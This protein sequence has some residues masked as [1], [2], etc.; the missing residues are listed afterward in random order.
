MFS[1][2]LNDCIL[3]AFSHETRGIMNYLAGQQGRLRSLKQPS[4]DDTHLCYPESKLFFQSRKKFSPSPEESCQLLTMPAC[5]SAAQIS[6]GTS[7][8]S[9]TWVGLIT[10][11]NCLL[12][13]IASAFLPE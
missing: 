3:N 6:P 8:E 9:Q 5:T 1:Y 10:L 12:K 13:L 11:K 2:R 4:T 7:A